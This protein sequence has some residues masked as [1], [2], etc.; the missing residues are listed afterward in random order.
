[1]LRKFL[2]AHALRNLLFVVVLI[3]GATGLGYLATLHHVQ[4][5]VT[6]NSIN[7]LGPTSIEVL[8]QC[9]VR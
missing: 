1:M 9:P 2:R 8:Q 3:G 5:D 4:R 6:Y 7:S